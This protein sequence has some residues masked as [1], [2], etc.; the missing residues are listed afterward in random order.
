MDNFE[1]FYNS[2]LED[3]ARHGR[4]F[5]STYMLVFEGNYER[6]QEL[7]Q[8]WFGENTTIFHYFTYLEIHA[9]PLP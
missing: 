4:R 5:Q 2:A 1:I 8:I 9:V 7:I 3:N 6:L